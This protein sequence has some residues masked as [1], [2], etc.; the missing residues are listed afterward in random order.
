[1]N[2]DSLLDLPSIDLEAN[3]NSFT[4]FTSTLR[5]KDVFAINY[6]LEGVD[7]SWRTADYGGMI[8]YNYLPPGTYVL[9][10]ACLQQEGL[11]GEIRSIQFKIAAPFYRTWWF[12]TIVALLIGALFFWI[13][14][15]R[16]RRRE[17][18][19][20]IRAD[21]ANNLHKEVNTALQNINILSEM[22]KIKVDK[23]I[24]KSKEFI[25]QIHSKSHTMIMAMDDMLWSIDPAN[26]SMEYT[27]LRMQEFIDALS[28]RHEVHI[29][30]LVEEKIKKLKLNM[31]FRHDAFILFRESLRT[32]IAARVSDVKVHLDHER[33]NIV[34]VVEGVNELSDLQQ[35]HNMLQ[36][37]E[38]EQRTRALKATLNTEVHKNTIVLNLTV[39]IQ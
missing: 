11:P 35:L 25:E 23:D 22:A 7:K 14:R 10:I 27:I 30:L 8:E 6:K 21:I 1:M 34:F 36:S 3:Q 18:L 33:N 12:Y 20:K 16:I 39:P 28:N 24:N 13:D 26:D 19:Y 2:V 4:V 9:K 29:S 17:Y 38:L 32:I 37:T 31:Q 15:E 5:F